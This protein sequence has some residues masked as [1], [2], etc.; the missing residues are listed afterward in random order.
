LN[1][2]IGNAF[3]TL[4][5]DSGNDSLSQ[6]AVRLSILVL[7]N[8]VNIPLFHLYSDLKFGVFQSEE[9]KRTV[10]IG[11]CLYLTHLF[12]HSAVTAREFNHSHTKSSLN[13]FGRYHS[14]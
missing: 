9:N 4:K 2:I 1:W 14:L 3:P 13:S 6:T 12:I 10:L 11:F 8:W 7:W 5:Y